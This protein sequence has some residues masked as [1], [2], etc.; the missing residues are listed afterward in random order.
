MCH[1]TPLSIPI[2]NLYLI[3]NRNS[4]FFKL[5]IVNIWTLKK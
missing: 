1:S 3:I 5:P 2:L 4:I